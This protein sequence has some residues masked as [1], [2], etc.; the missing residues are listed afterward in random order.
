ME[1]EVRHT[2][3]Y[4]LPFGVQAQLTSVN[5]EIVIIRLAKWTLCGSKIPNSNMTLVWHHMTIADFEGNQYI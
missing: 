2:S 5:I 1:R 3:L 4:T